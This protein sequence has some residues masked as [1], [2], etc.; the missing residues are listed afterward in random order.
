MKAQL[1]GDALFEVRG[2]L[3][4]G[5]SLALLPLLKSLILLT[6]PSFLPDRLRKCARSG[7]DEQK[8]LQTRQHDLAVRPG[9]WECSRFL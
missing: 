3:K 5:Q 8:S 9:N 1:R 7:S 6:L 4:G 2:G